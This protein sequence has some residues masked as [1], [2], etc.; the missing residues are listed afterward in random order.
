MFFSPPDITKHLFS[1]VEHWASRRQKKTKEQPL[2]RFR[3][4]KKAKSKTFFFF[5]QIHLFYLWAN[6]PPGSLSSVLLATHLT[7]F[8]FT[9]RWE[10]TRSHYVTIPQCRFMYSRVRV[11]GRRGKKKPNSPTAIIFNFALTRTRGPESKR[12]QR[13]IGVRSRKMKG[14]IW[15]EDMKLGKKKNRFEEELQ[16]RGEARRRWRLRAEAVEMSRKLQQRFSPE[17]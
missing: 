15:V 9:C 4:G 2:N 17:L 13:S 1:S 3:N 11:P 12:R 6:T 14:A 10:S 5:I 8:S 7:L 16:M